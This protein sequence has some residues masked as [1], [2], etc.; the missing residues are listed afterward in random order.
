M[1]RK[2]YE[3]MVKTVHGLRNEEYGNLASARQDFDYITQNSKTPTNDLPSV[4]A[5][6]IDRRPPADATTDTLDYWLKQ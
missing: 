3:V 6:L 2:R 1:S 4:E 5:W